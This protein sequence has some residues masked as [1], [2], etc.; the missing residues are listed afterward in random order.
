MA[1]ATFGRMS[2][3]PLSVLW[4]S[5]PS[6]AGKSSAGWEVFAQ[7]GRAGVT[8]AFVDGDQIGL[9]YPDPDGGP[10]AIRARNLAA[11]LPNFRREGVRR[12]VLA[13]FVDTR[14]EIG[15]YTSLMPDAAFTVCR[16]RVDA[17]ELERRFLG[18]GW[19]P[20]LVAQT[21]AEALA[22]DRTDYADLCVDSTGLTVGETAR[23]ILS[24][25]GDRPHTTSGASTTFG[26]STTNG[27][28]E[29]ST[30][31]GPT[32]AG[33][34]E[35]PAVEGEPVPVLW[36][37]GATGT[38]KS[39]VG[40]EVFSQVVRTG[41]RAAYVDVKQIGALRPA[42]H[43]D[44][45]LR[46]LVAGNLAAVWAGHRAAGARCLIVSG[47]PD[48]DDVI[49]ACAARLPKV[50]LTVCR[51]HAAPATLAERIRLRAGG[52]APQLPGDEL[53][54]LG[55]RALDRV[56]ERAAA[57]AEALERAGSGDLRL[58]TDGRAAQELATLV[59]ERALPW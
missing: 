18:R 45:D 44:P 43:D 40:Y 53:K 1:A 27:R 58:E 12:V 37:S 23:L 13:G 3:V 21:V 17:G 25:T 30:M 39:T 49:R 4:L 6:G 33:G 51:V 46:R 48:T 2:D 36:F 22:Q 32:P 8:A 41:V 9:C 52:Q 24:R 47:G 42:P 57:E 34:F 31:G 29:A 50:D 5:G 7:L 59:R 55:P 10:H 16:L 15:A 28:N 14:D 38:G 26:P 20:D 56:A 19:R 35:G 11:M 54:G